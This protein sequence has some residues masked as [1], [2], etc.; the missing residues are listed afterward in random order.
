MNFSGE[1]GHP[2][3]QYSTRPE[4]EPGTPGLEGRHLTITPTRSFESSPKVFYFQQFEC[5]LD[6]K[7]LGLTFVNAR[8]AVNH[9]L[10]VVQVC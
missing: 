1:E 4:N 5:V 2:D 3:I 8:G 7:I 6:I 9:T 10:E